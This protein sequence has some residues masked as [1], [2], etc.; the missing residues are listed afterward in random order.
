MVCMLWGTTLFSMARQTQDM[1]LWYDK[2]ALNF[3][4]ALPLGNGRIAAMLYGSPTEEMLVLNEET[5]SKGSPYSNH[6]PET[7]KHLGNLRRLIF[8]EK[9]DSAQALGQTQII[10]PRPMGNGGAYQT[11]GSLHVNFIDHGG[12][13]HY[14]RS[15]HLDSAIA[16]VSYR[17][18]NI[19]YKEEA[20]TSMTDQLLVVRYTASKKHAINFDAYLS[21]PTGGKTPTYSAQGNTLTLKGTTDDAGKDVLG[22]VKFTVTA[23]VE[24]K[25]GHISTS[26]NVLRVREASEVI[27]YVAMATNFNNYRDISADASQR[28]KEHLTNSHKNYKTLKDNHVARYQEQFHRVR[29]NLGDNTNASLPTDKRLQQFG[30]NG[31]DNHLVSLYFQYGRYLLI[32]S[33]QPGCQPANLQG[34]WNA[35]LNPAWKC[36]YTININTEMNY[37]PAE[38]CNLQEM[39]EPLVKMIRELSEAGRTTARNMYGCRGWVSHHNTDLWRMTGAVDKV[40]S[41]AW[42]TSNAWLCQ[43]LWNRYLFNG[44]K[45]YLA[46]VYPIMKGAAEFFVDFMTEDP[47][48]HY[49]VVCPSVSP[50]HGPKGSGYLR[51]GIAMDNQ[52]VSNLFTQTASAAHI[53]G[54][55]G[56]FA[57]TLLQMRNRIMPL[58]IGKHGQV[59]EWAEDMDSPT[60]T[61]RHVS[62]LWA[63][64]PGTLLSPFRTPSACDA[65]RTTLRHRGDHSTGWSMGWKVCLWAHLLD[66]N[67]AYQLVKEQLTFVPDSIEKGSGGTYPNLFDAHPPFQID[68]NFGCTAGIAEMLVQ[69]HDGA[70]HLLPALPSQWSQGRVGGLRAVGGF[71]VEDLQWKDGK[72][73]SV[74]VK[75]TLGGNLRIRSA[76]P[77]RS[78]NRHLHKAEGD[79][80]NHLFQTW[81]MPVSRSSSDGYTIINEKQNLQTPVSYL[82][83]IDT[84]EGE[85]V[86]LY[87]Y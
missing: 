36:R 19:E 85:T 25:G 5:I 56:A 62:H 48:Y 54:K 6:N 72:L 76:V 14:R 46:E 23:K 51:S 28:V 4:S 73:Q 8:E 71:V 68:G 82:Y 63:M 49:L 10:G 52:L 47:R 16:T 66:G 57:D 87:T 67:H 3:N 42:P 18:G 79:N 50:E 7:W 86:T 17:V 9:Y 59:Q 60:D 58:R 80:P 26:G 1:E 75:S 33:S 74:S 81:T 24:N 39:H 45:K 12:Y 78:G 64:F 69:S 43:H 29:L 40:Y 77:L 83:D 37:W 2:P 34:K 84:T 11:A 44:D 61:H 22:K 13:S 20:F 32:S 27:V 35:K 55:D 53:L 41:G 30:T 21:Y 15:L 31:D 38:T 65:V 70:V